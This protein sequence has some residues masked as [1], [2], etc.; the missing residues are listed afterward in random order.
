M[1]SI[2]IGGGDS[3]SR[4]LGLQIQSPTTNEI[5]VSVCQAIGIARYST[6]ERSAVLCEMSHLVSIPW[7]E[8]AA[9]SGNTSN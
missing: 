3:Y 7:P 6:R 4:Q 1:L 2:C 5:D 8:C 9:T